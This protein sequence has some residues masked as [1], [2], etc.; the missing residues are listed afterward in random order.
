MR[1]I[2]KFQKGASI[3]RYISEKQAILIANKI[4]NKQ[5]IIKY[6]LYDALKHSRI[7]YLFTSHNIIKDYGVKQ[8]L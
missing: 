6:K 1:Y 2:P 8:A 4:K 7:R 3:K 5:F